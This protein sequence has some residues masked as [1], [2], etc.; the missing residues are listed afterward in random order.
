MKLSDFSLE[1]LV[2]FLTGDDSIAPYMS[3]PQLISFFNKFG[4]C[5]VYSHKDGGLPNGASRKEYTL[6]TLKE[7]NGT[8]SFRGM[9]EGIVD[10]RR[11]QNSDEM[12]AAVN[13]IIKHD[14]Y[15]L[16]INFDEV[17]KVSGEDPEDKVDI[18]AHFQQIRDQIIESIRSAKLAV[19]V[20]VA[21]FTDKDIA[22]ELREKHRAGLNIQVIVNDDETSKRYGIDF[23]TRGIE[24]YMGNPSSEFGKKIMH[25]KFCIIDFKKVIHGSYNWTNNATYNDEGITITDSRE[26]AENF[27]QQFI[28][29][30]TNIINANRSKR[31]LG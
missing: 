31:N 3:G 5:D 17:Y 24:F 4:V 18:Q 12:A 15:K 10:G 16:E 21:W 13:Q 29:L 7:L 9:V 11:V 22:N 26:L 20:A 6:T 14:K 19:W 8:P 25:N 30:K 1:A 28:L 27:A 23:S 2:P